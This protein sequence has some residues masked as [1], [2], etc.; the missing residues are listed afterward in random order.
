MGN[1]CKENGGIFMFTQHVAEELDRANEELRRHLSSNYW[2]DFNR[3]AMQY[4][5][6]ERRGPMVQMIFPVTLNGEPIPFISQWEIRAAVAFVRRRR[7]PEQ[8]KEWLD[9]KE[10]RKWLPDA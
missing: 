8:Q 3:I 5:L 9:R 4:E 7:R 10:Y 2:F 1:S 6:W